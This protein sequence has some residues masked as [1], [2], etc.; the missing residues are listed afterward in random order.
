MIAE[1]SERFCMKVSRAWGESM[2]VSI[3]VWKI[4]QTAVTSFRSM[5][6]GTKAR[7]WNGGMFWMSGVC[8]VV[9]IRV[10]LEVIGC[11]FCLIVVCGV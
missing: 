2:L 10:P 7:G 6:F 1:S 9:M 3:S 11:L 8:V 5:L 4:L